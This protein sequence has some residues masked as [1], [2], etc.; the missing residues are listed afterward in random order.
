MGNTRSRLSRW[1]AWTGSAPVP[2][3]SRPWLRRGAEGWNI[4]VLILRF[5]PSGR[6][7][8][9]KGW[10]FDA[11]PFHWA[12]RAH[13]HLAA[14]AS[15]SGS[16]APRRYLEYLLMGTPEVGEL[17]LRHS[18]RRAPR[19]SAYRRRRNRPWCPP[20]TV[21]CGDDVSRHGM[22]EIGFRRWCPRVPRR[23]KKPRGLRAK[24]RGGE[25]G[26]GRVGTHQKRA[27]LGPR[28][29]PVGC[30]F[31]SGPSTTSHLSVSRAPGCG[32]KWSLS[33]GASVS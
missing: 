10:G 32:S 21:V 8:G 29:H 27:R 18:P 1:L 33:V 12:C 4:N 28:D 30:V 9:T 24:S 26:S 22:V 15:R 17:L 7:D 31:D 13:P 14:L 16:S 25:S 3:R 6:C 5:G 23:V 2:T 19:T 11:R 20:G